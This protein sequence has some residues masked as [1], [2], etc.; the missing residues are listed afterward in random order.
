MVENDEC[1][2]ALSSH[3]QRILLEA[4]VRRSFGRQQP[5][6]LPRRR[7]SVSPVVTMASDAPPTATPSSTAVRQLWHHHLQ[8]VVLSCMTALWLQQLLG[9]MDQTHL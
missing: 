7:H 1:R 2:L 3:R 8:S 9:A 6:L 4:E 5:A